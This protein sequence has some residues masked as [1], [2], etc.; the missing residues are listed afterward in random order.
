MSYKT[1][2]VHLHDNTRRDTALAAG[3]GLART[4]GAHLIGLSVQPPLVVVPSVGGGDA[5]VIDD[6]RRGYVDD[7]RRLRSA[8][9]AA[10]AGQPF[11]AEW[12]AIDPGY[13]QAIDSVLDHGRSADLVIA[14]QKDT[15]WHLTEHLEAPDRLVMECGRPVLLLPKSGEVHPFGERILVAWNGRRESARAVFDAVPLLQ[16]AKEVIVVWLNPQDDGETA[17]DLP[18]VDICQALARHGVR[19]EATRNIRPAGDVGEALLT[20]AETQAAD[21]LVMGCYGHSRLRE[22]VFGG[23][24][25]HVLNHMHIPV[26]MAH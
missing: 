22:Y 9:D 5:I 7:E 11:V 1:I 12:R 16:R 21:M 14:S 13:D 20:T 19:C 17:G 24:T 8:F 6:H 26:L 4:F 3:C 15:D 18:G 2:L 23:A 10:V 25:R